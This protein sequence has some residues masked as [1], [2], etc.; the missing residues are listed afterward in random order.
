V[1]TN[2]SM[3]F[4]PPER[5][6]G[7]EREHW[8]PSPEVRAREVGLYRGT[9]LTQMKARVPAALFLETSWFLMYSLWRSGGLMLVGMALY[10]WGVLSAERGA[11]FYRCCIL[12]G[13]LAGL[14]I[15]AF[16]AYLDLRAGWSVR[17]SLFLGRQF[18]EWGSIP[19]TLAYIGMV[20]L[21]CQRGV[22]TWLTRRLAAVGQM[23]FTNY[24]AQ[25]L[26]CTTVFYGHGLGLFG[27][28]SRSRQLAWMAGIWL[29]QL[30]WSP[31]WLARF[32]L[33]PLEWLW[34][35]LTYGRR[36]PLRRPTAA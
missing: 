23:A 9:W 24:L 6:A 27:S 7:L 11:A 22:A 21:A 5:I 10:K 35:S 28:V 8:L 16:G 1:I 17:Y 32:R 2:W 34:R 33:G 14:P 15:I 3:R 26:I 36:Q 31:W 4:W 18:N 13:V 30:A 19:V 12:T 20:M 29:L 25:T